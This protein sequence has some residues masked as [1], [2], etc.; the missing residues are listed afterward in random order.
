MS[1]WIVAYKASWKPTKQ[2]EEFADL[3]ATARLFSNLYFSLIYE[4]VGG[5]RFV[6][7]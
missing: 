4:E 2:V 7:A 5:E 3:P 6:A 1:N